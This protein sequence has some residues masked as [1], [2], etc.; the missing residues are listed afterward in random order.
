[1][2]DIGIYVRDDS[3][4]NYIT[5]LLT[6]YFHCPPYHKNHSSSEWYLPYMHVAIRLPSQ[7][8]GYRVDL[9]YYD[10]Y[11]PQDILQEV[12]FPTCLWSRPKPL[13]YL[14]DKIKDDID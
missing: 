4:C 8:R 14:I 7:A 1:M 9:A 12:I 6:N 11:I 2:I 13:E 3:Q 10:K 5:T